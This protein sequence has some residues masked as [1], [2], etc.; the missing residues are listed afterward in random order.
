MLALAAAGHDKQ[1]AASQTWAELVEFAGRTMPHAAPITRDS[2]PETAR[3]RHAPIAD[4]ILTALNRL[5]SH[6]QTVLDG[7][8]TTLADVVELRREKPIADVLERLEGC[9]S[10]LVTGPAGF[11]KSAIAKRAVEQLAADNIVLAFRSEELAASHLDQSLHQ[12]QIGTGSEELFAAMAGQ[13]RKVILVESVERLLESSQREAFLDLLRLVANDPSWRLVLTCRDYSTETVRAAFIKQAEL[14]YAISEV[15]ELTTE[16]LAE[17]VAAIPA[18]RV[19]ASHPFLEKLFRN[20]YYLDKAAS[21]A[22]P[23]G[24]D[25][26]ASERAFRQK[27]WREVVRHEQHADRGMPKRRE[28]AFIAL[29][30][31][32]AQALQ[33]FVPVKGL[34]PRRLTNY[35]RTA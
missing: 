1:A 27:F 18:L 13:G 2:L 7:I 28:Q 9:R 35:T 15:P 30:V 5:R 23:P 31:R 8:R 10:V 17:A 22:W 12:A 6:S 14:P 11:G 24:T 29:G 20:P 32:R 4:A 19:P 33:P 34:I 25:F 3:N 21:M 26:P 16:E